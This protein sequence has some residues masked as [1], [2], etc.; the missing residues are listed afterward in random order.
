MKAGGS[1]GPPDLLMTSRSCIQRH[2]EDGRWTIVTSAPCAPL[3]PF[4]RGDYAGWR[5]V[6]EHL[7]RR[8]EVPVLMIPLII[9]FEAPFEIASPETAHPAPLRARSFL[10]GAHDSFS[11]VDSAGSTNCVQVN[12]TFHGA[13]RLFRC[14]MSALHNRVLP[15][16]DVAGKEGRQLVERLSN[17]RDWAARFDHLDSYL[18]R[19]LPGAS[20]ADGRVA[21]AMAGIAASRGQCEIRDLAA[22]LDVTPKRLIADFHR[23]VGLSP[24]TVARLHRF[25]QARRALTR[26]PQA[27]ALAEIALGAGYYDQA[28]FNRDFRKFAGVSPTAFIAE[29]AARPGEP[30]D[31]PD[32]NS[33]QDPIATAP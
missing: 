18:M 19:R 26:W 12:L 31:A 10:A 4:I 32:G 5:E 23:Q 7:I 27:P 15:F 2:A 6:S 3:R 22:R 11:L 20:E 21:L 9:G 14:P 17:A 8:R 33:V 28:H 25:D 16:E 24:K 1:Q 29:L 13:S 30:A